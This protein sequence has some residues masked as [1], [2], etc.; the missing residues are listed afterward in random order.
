MHSVFVHSSSTRNLGEHYLA[1]H[2][3][4][5]LSILAVIF[6]CHL[7][8]HLS[9]VSFEGLVNPWDVLVRVSKN[10]HGGITTP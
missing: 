8:V 3:T 1:F 5:L 4:L 2:L 10:P 7:C 6:L 9:M